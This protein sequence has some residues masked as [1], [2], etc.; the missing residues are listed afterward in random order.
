ML[1]LVVIFLLSCAGYRRKNL[2]ENQ[3]G[4]SLS[5]SLISPL[6]WSLWFLCFRERE[7]GERE[8]SVVVS[9]GGICLKECV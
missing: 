9:K 3:G 8:G 7:R 2:D 1:V 4:P 5:L 6:F